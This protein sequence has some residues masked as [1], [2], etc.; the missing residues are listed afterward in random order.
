[1]NIWTTTNESWKEKKGKFLQKSFQ[2][3]TFPISLANGPSSNFHQETWRLQQ[4]NENMQTHHRKNINF[5]C[6]VQFISKTKF[7]FEIFDS[8]TYWDNKDWQYIYLSY[9]VSF[10]TGKFSPLKNHS[11]DNWK[12]IFGNPRCQRSSNIYTTEPRLKLHLYT[13]SIFMK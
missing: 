1:M 6:I 7:F 2:A 12:P 5:W 3:I 8:K 10:V 11:T 13:L 9:S 4:K